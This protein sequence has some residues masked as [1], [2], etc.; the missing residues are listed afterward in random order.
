MPT[1]AEMLVPQAGFGPPVV[2]EGPRDAGQFWI[3]GGEDAAFAAGQDFGLLQAEDSNV[4][5]RSCPAAPL[6]GCSLCLSRI[7]YDKQIMPSG[8]LAQPGHVRDVSAEMD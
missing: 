8:N 7:F 3:I 4:A 1:E 5:E 2:P 6:Q